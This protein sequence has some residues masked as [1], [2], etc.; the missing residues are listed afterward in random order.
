M[1]STASRAYVCNGKMI[2]PHYLIVSCRRLSIFKETHVTIKRPVVPAS[3]GSVIEIVFTRSRRRA[4][5]NRPENGVAPCS[6]PV[7]GPTRSTFTAA[8]LDRG[9]RN[10]NRLLRD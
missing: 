9:K 4:D 6:T 3:V 1:I 10:R 7:V 2:L 8:D 5:E